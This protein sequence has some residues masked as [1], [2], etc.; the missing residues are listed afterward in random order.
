MTDY[1]TNM[2]NSQWQVIKGY[3]NDHRKRR[4]SFREV[5]NAIF[6]LVKTGCQWRMLPS[7]FPRWQIV[8]YYFSKWKSDGTLERLRC[9]LVKRHRK[10]NGRKAQPTAAVMDAQSV[11]NTLVS[12]S[13][14]TGYDGGK[15]IKG[16][17]RHIVVDTTGMLLC[18]K[19][20]SAGIADRHGGRLVLGC[21]RKNWRAIKKLFVDGGYQLPGK[22]QRKDTPINGYEI[23]IV[24]RSDIKIGEVAPKRWV[25]E[26]TFA[27]FETN[28]RNAK[29]YERLPDTAEAIVEICA[30]RQI[31]NNLWP[32]NF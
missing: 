7:G 15:R 3:L 13:C 6:Y 12:R 2:S 30:I 1:P 5:L 29:G 16:I 23:E 28:R 27:W 14:D 11:K 9:S 24:K 10:R 32:P 26:R 8:Y 19:V 22:N 17:K 21:L 20:H 25:V 31:L 4:Y 18:V